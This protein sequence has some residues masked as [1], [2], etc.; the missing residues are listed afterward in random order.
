VKME[1]TYDFKTDERFSPYPVKLKVFEGP[2]DL[3]LFLIK[4]NEIDIYDI[5]ISLI[6]QQYLEYL[7]MMRS[8]D[9]E[10]AGEFV[11]MAATLIR[12]KAQMLLPKTDEGET[13]EDPRAQLVAA[14]LEYKKFKELS[15]VLQQKEKEE[16]RFFPRCDFSYLESNNEK[17]DEIEVSLYD[18]LNAFKKV[19][20]SAPEE[21]IHR[22][23]IEEV[24][25]NQRVH[26]VLSCLKS[27]ERVKFT[28]LF[29]DNPIR[30]V[31]VVTFIAI[32]E[33]IRL[34]KIKIVQRRNFSQIWVYRNS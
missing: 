31:M 5:P 6:T 2:L 30:L 33:L 28:E 34:K 9:L 3:L 16:S 26:H 7:E 1:N 22:V 14:L 15:G 13:E 11:L 8:L 23:K 17:N 25:L 32:L 19:W 12:I 20:R 18:L 10:V 4:K 24:N 29:L 21:I 27:K